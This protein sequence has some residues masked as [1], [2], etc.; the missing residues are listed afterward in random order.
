VTVPDDGWPRWLARPGRSVLPSGREVLVGA[1]EESWVTVELG[2]G[3][4]VTVDDD[5]PHGFLVG[6]HRARTRHDGP[7]ATR[8]YGV[9]VTVRYDSAAERLE[10]AEPPFTAHSRDCEGCDHNLG[11]AFS[12]WFDRASVL[13]VVEVLASL[14]VDPR[15]WNMPDAGLPAWRGRLDGDNRALVELL[16]ADE[17]SWDGRCPVV[18]RV[19]LGL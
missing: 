5:G 17:A 14:P 6:L 4:R 18:A 8:P 12:A 11:S 9:E 13:P 2:A 16:P 7:P 3:V 1:R 15:P 19:D 10:I